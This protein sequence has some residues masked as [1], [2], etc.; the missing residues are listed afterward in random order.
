MSGTA[1]A[2]SSL[3]NC[4]S[5]REGKPNPAKSFSKYCWHHICQYAISQNKSCAKGPEQ[6][7]TPHHSGRAL[8]ND[9]IKGVYRGKSNEMGLLCNLP[10]TDVT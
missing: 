2:C 6:G 4:R 7:I 10:Q 1:L 8:Q 5:T 3:D 9:T